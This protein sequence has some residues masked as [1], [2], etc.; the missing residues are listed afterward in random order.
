MP[1]EIFTV[2][3]TS[4]CELINETFRKKMRKIKQTKTPHMI[5]V[6]M[7][8]LCIGTK[9]NLK[10][11]SFPSWIFKYELMQQNEENFRATCKT[12]KF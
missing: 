1:I 5:T 3:I 2:T 6:L 7:N 11:K 9:L 12:I 10:K 4:R 8:V